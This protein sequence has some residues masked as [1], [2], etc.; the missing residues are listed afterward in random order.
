M[1]RVRRTLGKPWFITALFTGVVLAGV[2]LYWF[3][4]WKLWVDETVRD[5]F[6]VAASVPSP[7]AAGGTTDA[8]PEE[9]ATGKLISHEHATSG[10]VRVLRLAD[11][12]RV[13]RLTGLETSNGPALRVW[14]SDA[15]VK[16]GKDGWHVFDDG[17][18]V[19]LGELK[20]NKGDQNYPLP[21]DVDLDD[22]RS[23]T[24][25]CDRFDVSFGATE[26]TRA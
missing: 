26:L 17:R 24:I 25:W 10:S 8:G 13:L 2:G 19:S 23:V 4:P 6:P 1:G 11:G 22:Y 7:D 9:L 16:P 21:A 5:P 20:G 14:L 18:H 3:Q 12:T 15:E